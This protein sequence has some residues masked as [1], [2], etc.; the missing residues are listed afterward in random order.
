MAETLSG[1]ARQMLRGE[2]N[3]DNR[4]VHQTVEERTAGGRRRCSRYVRKE[5][6]QKKTG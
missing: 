6:V 2:P 1:G 3:V 4:A 5:P